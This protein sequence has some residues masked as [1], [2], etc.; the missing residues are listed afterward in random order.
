M[1]IDFHTHILKET[2]LKL[3]KGKLKELEEKTGETNVASREILKYLCDQGLLG[4]TVPG[5]YGTGPEKMSLISFCL[6]REMRSS[7]WS[8]PDNY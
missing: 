8:L 3:T 2:V 5:K 6:A 1:I 7:I 4:L